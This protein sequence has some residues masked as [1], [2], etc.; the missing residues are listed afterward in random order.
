[1]GGRHRKK[2]SPAKA[3]VMYISG[4]ALVSAVALYAVSNMTD[5]YIPF[6]SPIAQAPVPPVE[7]TTAPVVPTTPGPGATPITPGEIPAGGTQPTQTPENG[8][9]RPSQRAVQPPVTTSTIPPTQPPRTQDQKPPPATTE[10]PA[11]AV[12]L[13]LLPS[14]PVPQVLPKLLG[15]C[16]GLNVLSQVSAGCNDILRAVPGVTQTIGRAQRPNNP[17]SCHPKGLALDLMVYGNGA[18]G[19]RLAAY[20]RVNKTRLGITTIL[21]RVPDHFDH[22]HLSFAP[23]YY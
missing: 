20:A 4:L 13:P 16:S 9:L 14:I 3:T 15:L 10:R 17:T 21:W 19:D 6:L 12:K 23:C 5:A 2:M 22:V 7:S 1:M 11:P 18:L 8:D